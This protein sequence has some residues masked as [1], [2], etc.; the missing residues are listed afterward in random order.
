M[1]VIVKNETLKDV[2]IKA[3]IVTIDMTLFGVLLKM[4]FKFLF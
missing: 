2:H 1:Q 4:Y 3:L